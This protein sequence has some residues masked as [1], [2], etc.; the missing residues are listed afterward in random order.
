MSP[1]PCLAHDTLH[2][3][4]RD[5]ADRPSRDPAYQ[6][7]RG[8]QL[9]TRGGGTGSSKGGWLRTLICAHTSTSVYVDRVLMH[10]TN[11]QKARSMPHRYSPPC[12]SLHFLPLPSLSSRAGEGEDLSMHSLNLEQRTCCR[13]PAPVCSLVCVFFCGVCVSSPF[14]VL[15]PSPLHIRSAAVHSSTHYP[16]HAALPSFR[17]SFVVR[18]VPAIISLETSVATR[19]G[20]PEACRGHFAQPCSPR[21]TTSTRHLCV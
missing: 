17:F 14:V 2:R 13:L 21:P 15:Y 11:K 10:T 5:P 20:S 18:L 12:I 16:A 9:L 4:R 1:L 6:P 19:Q 8:A 7:Q 3:I